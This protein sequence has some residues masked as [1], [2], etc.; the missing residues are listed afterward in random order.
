MNMFKRI[1]DITVATLNEKLEQSQDPVRLIDQFLLDTR[2]EIAEAEQLHNS[3]SHHTRQLNHHVEKASAMRQKREEQAMLA[4]KAEEEEL[5]RMALQEKVMYEEKEN[6]YHDLLDKNKEALNEIEY[7]LNTL[8]SEYQIVYSKREYYHARME[9]LRL[10]QQMNR[11]FGNGGGNMP[12]FN[13]LEDRISDWEL[14]A[15]AVRDVRQMDSYPSG[16]SDPASA[17]ALDAEL[18]R[19][20]RK[21]DQQ[22][23][24]G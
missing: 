10:Q 17:I 24:E 18:E 13:R 11:R 8:K 15:K 20:R 23:K 5:A 7:Q 9:T 16:G 12:S 2:Q 14:E 21:L 6:Q 1:R 4:L 22:R 19:L 3:I